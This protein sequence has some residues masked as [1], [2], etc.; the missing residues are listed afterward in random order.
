MPEHAR[1]CLATELATAGAAAT[2]GWKIRL[3]TGEQVTSSVVAQ[4]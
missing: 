4:S 2:S 1:P 3:D